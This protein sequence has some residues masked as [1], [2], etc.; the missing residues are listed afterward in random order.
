MKKL[1]HFDHILSPTHI[2]ARSSLPPHSL[3]LCFLSAS[4]SLSLSLSFSVSLSKI[5]TETKLKPIK[6]KVKKHT[7]T[8]QIKKHLGKP[9]ILFCLGQLLLGM[10][11]ALDWYIHPVTLH[12]RNLIFPSFQQ[13]WITNSFLV[14]RGI[15]CP[16]SLLSSGFCLVWGWAGLVCAVSVWEKAWASALLSWAGRCCFLGVIYRLW[17]LPSFHLL[18]YKNRWA[19]RAGVW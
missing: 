8:Q 18:F 1:L 11:P 19:P 7:T 14:K 5:K 13:V 16:L 3:T 9:W 15:L 17:P 12:W 2:P 6:W 4:V 10:G